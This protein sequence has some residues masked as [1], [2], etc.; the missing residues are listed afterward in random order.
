MTSIIWSAWYDGD[1]PLAV[2]NE[3]LGAPWMD[4]EGNASDAVKELSDTFWLGCDSLWTTLAGDSDSF[5]VIVEVHSP[6][7]IA[8]RYN[9]RLKKVIKSSI[10][11]VTR[12]G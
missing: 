8:G 11:S 10:K 5:D 4:C 1:K 2:R 7:S 12:S 3:F 6:L 9:V